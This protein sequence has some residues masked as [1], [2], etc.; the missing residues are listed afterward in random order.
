M[1]RYHHIDPFLIAAV[2][3]VETNYRDQAESHKGA[4]GLMQL[5]PDT[6]EWIIETADIRIRDPKDI[7]K[8][9]VNINLRHLVF[10]MAN[11]AL[12]R[13]YGICNRSL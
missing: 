8:R 13:Q 7:W 9:D 2:I 10:T 6:A 12:R 1:R 4:I 5:M 11:Q 3:R